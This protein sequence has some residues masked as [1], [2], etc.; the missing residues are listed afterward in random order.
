MFCRKCGSK[1]YDD[2]LFCHRCGTKIMSI[3]NES[4]T[5]TN[6]EADSVITNKEKNVESSTKTN[7]ASDIIDPEIDN[8]DSKAKTA[9]PS[10][11]KTK[12]SSKIWI[13][14]PI[15]C[16]FFSVYFIVYAV[17][18]LGWEEYYRKEYNAL[19][20]SIDPVCA[21][22]EVSDALRTKCAKNANII[23]PLLEESSLEKMVFNK[24]TER[25]GQLNNLDSYIN[26]LES[27]AQRL[28]TALSEAE[29]E[30]VPES[31]DD[32]M[33]SFD[34]ESIIYAYR[35]YRNNLI[36]SFNNFS[37][38]YE[39]I[40]N[41]QSFQ[42]EGDDG[43][44]TTNDDDLGDILSDAAE[45]S[46]KE[47]NLKAEISLAELELSASTEPGLGELILYDGDYFLTNGVS[48]AGFEQRT[49]EAIQHASHANKNMMVRM[50]T[51]TVLALCFIV[52]MI[53]FLILRHKR[54]S[55]LRR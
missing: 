27:D 13:L 20:N 14:V 38:K 50:I 6:T 4:K 55:V 36:S 44:G 2:E 21:K 17:N 29:K 9:T 16:L 24:D 45:Q 11:V 53:I 43:S 34:V 40:E 33:G 22:L 26:Q 51:Y 31:A 48:K 19:S 42:E 46:G 49:R 1:L 28:N 8:H 15:I 37:E 39:Q 30:N 3:E 25:V 41:P 35:T 23:Y 32:D 47:A 7:D 54:K 52:G 18:S 5:A 10:S 12:K